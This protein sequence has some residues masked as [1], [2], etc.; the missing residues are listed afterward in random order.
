MENDFFIKKLKIGSIVLASVVAVLLIIWFATKVDH[1]S[2][3]NN[4]YNDN[5]YSNSNNVEGC[6]FNDNNY[7]DAMSFEDAI[8]SAYAA[9]GINEDPVKYKN[10]VETLKTKYYRIIPVEWWFTSIDNY[11]LFLSDESACNKGKESLKYFICKIKSDKSF[12][13]NRLAD[14]VFEQMKDVELPTFQFSYMLT[15]VYCGSE[16]CGAES[17]INSWDDIT[18]NSAIFVITT[19]MDVWIRYTFTRV[20][21]LWYL[22]EY[23]DITKSD[24]W[25]LMQ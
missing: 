1:E 19:G 2:N 18:D 8:K 13:M 25:G 21:G 9:S 17:V 7:F 23:T 10:Y 20:D 22:S 4:V 15:P 11:R 3:S 14:G 5:H 24:D 6:C 16:I 12:L